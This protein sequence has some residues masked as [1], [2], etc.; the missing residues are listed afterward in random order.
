MKA[1][2]LRAQTKGSSG[3]E[4]TSAGSRKCAYL[5][6]AATKVSDELPHLAAELMSAAHVV[7][8][9]NNLPRAVFKVRL[10]HGWR[11]ER[12]EVVRD[13]DLLLFSR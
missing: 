2:S 10:G 1:Q 12:D 13:S 9:D 8:R 5:Q 11:R 7:A 3:A 4:H 6:E